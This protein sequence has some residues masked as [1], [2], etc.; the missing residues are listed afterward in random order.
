MYY[1]PCT[2]PTRV[3]RFY[4]SGC[5]YWK[6]FEYNCPNRA[7]LKPPF[8]ALHSGDR[9]AMVM[10][11]SFGALRSN[12]AKPE[13]LAKCAAS[14]FT[15]SMWEFRRWTYLRSHRA[16]VLFKSRSGVHMSATTTDVVLDP[17]SNGEDLKIKFIGKTK[18]PLTAVT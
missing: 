9:M 4:V 17:T 10:T 1:I 14:C 18:I 16:R 2:S 13:G 12:A 6:R 5:K 3:H 7:S 15:R 11:T 8:F